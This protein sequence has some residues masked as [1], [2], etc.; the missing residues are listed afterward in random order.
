MLTPTASVQSP[1]P[2]VLPPGVGNNITYRSRYNEIC[3]FLHQ[4]PS[5]TFGIDKLSCWPLVGGGSERSIMIVILYWF[6]K[7]Y[8]EL[9]GPCFGTL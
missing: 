3:Q 9:C 5:Q 8:S 7:W 6:E 2:G 1:R 4:V